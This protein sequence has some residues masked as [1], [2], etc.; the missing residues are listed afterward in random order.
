MAAAGNNF[1]EG[2]RFLYFPFARRY[3]IILRVVLSFYA[4]GKTAR[5]NEYPVSLALEVLAWKMKMIARGN[6]R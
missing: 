3:V 1:C 2:I 6:G 4:G 5:K